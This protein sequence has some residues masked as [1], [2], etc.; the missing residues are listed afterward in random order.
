MGTCLALFLRAIASVDNVCRKRGI[1]IAQ[2]ICFGMTSVA[3]ECS[4]SVVSK[5]MEQ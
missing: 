1:A 2:S 3:V 4:F 5:L